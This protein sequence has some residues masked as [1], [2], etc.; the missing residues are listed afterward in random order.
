MEVTFD[1]KDEIVERL[2]QEADRCGKSMSDVVESA[3]QE[4]LPQPEPAAPQVKP[5]REPLPPLPTWNS[6]GF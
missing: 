6:G 1:I 5:A 4:N 2:R 3:L